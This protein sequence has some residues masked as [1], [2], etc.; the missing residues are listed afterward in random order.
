[1]YSK[2]L[3]TE[4]TNSFSVKLLTLNSVLFVHVSIFFNNVELKWVKR[5]VRRRK[6]DKD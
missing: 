5:R 6:R 2:K 4:R 3:L 1:M